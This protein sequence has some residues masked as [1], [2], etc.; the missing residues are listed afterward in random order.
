MA[1]AS[2]IGI[3]LLFSAAAWVYLAVPGAEGDGLP[4][5]LPAACKNV[6]TVVYCCVMFAILSGL[7]C[8]LVFLYVNGTFT[9]DLKLLT[10]TAV[11]AVAN[12]TDMREHKI[13]N[14]LVITALAV[15]IVYA[16]TEI[17]MYG[18]AYF[19]TLKSDLLSL[20]FAL[21]FLLCGLVFM[22]SGVGMGDIKL[23][24]IMG[25]FLGFTGTVSSLFFSL[26][27]A[28]V[29]SV[30]LLISRKKT[31]KDAIAFAPSLFAGTIISIV[32]TGI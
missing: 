20:I 32:L 30:I 14:K 24:A 13:P 15:R 27:I 9:D 6:K 29:I 8:E 10:I 18:S 12:A 22:K 25:L 4:K 1:L 17:C 3:S 11:L 19:D 26:I 21:A 31:R 23:I 28:F 5:K 2:L 16:V 7:S